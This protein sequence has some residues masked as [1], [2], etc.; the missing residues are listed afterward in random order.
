LDLD[1]KDENVREWEVRR[2]H[3]RL[4]E[5]QRHG[6][7]INY[8]PWTPEVGLI[9]FLRDHRADAERAVR[10]HF[11]DNRLSIRVQD[12]G[13][14]PGNAGKEQRDACKTAVSRVTDHLVPYLANAGEEH[15]RRGLFRV[16]AKWYFDRNRAAVMALIGPLVAGM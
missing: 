5:F 4:A 12:I 1:V 15:A 10:Q 13:H 9:E 16:F 3:T 6:N 7:R 2:N 8:L 11:G 14:I